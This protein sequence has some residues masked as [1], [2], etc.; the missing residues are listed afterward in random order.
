MW[1][2]VLRV[3]EVEDFSELDEDTQRTQ[4]KAHLA[5]LG[6]DLLG[7]SPVNAEPV[8]HVPGRDRG[9]R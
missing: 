1:A 3:G 7:D 9:V 4:H 5:H 6:D 2:W 8:P